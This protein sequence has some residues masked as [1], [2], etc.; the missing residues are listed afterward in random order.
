MRSKS[1][2]TRKTLPLTVSA[3]MSTLSVIL[4][5]LYNVPLLNIIAVFTCALP[6]TYAGAIYGTRWAILSCITSSVVIGMVQSPL[7]AYWFLMLF[8]IM[9]AV[10]GILLHRREKPGKLLFKGT[11]ITV[12]FFILG[13]Y[14]VESAMGLNEV[15][16]I[17]S[18]MYHAKSWAVNLLGSPKPKPDPA[19]ALSAISENINTLIS[20]PQFLL[21]ASTRI[22][23]FIS[24]HFLPVQGIADFLSEEFKYR[25]FEKITSSYFALQTLTMKVAL[26]VQP[27]NPFTLESAYALRALMPAMDWEFKRIIVHMFSEQELEYEANM[28][29]AFRLLRDWIKFP[30][31][32]SLTSTLPPLF[33][34]YF[35]AALIFPRFGTYIRPLPPLFLWKTPELIV[36]A[37]LFSQF[38]QAWAQFN[39]YF[40]MANLFQQLFIG[41]SMMTFLTGVGV[42]MFFTLRHKV[43]GVFRLF[44]MMASIFIFPFIS[45]L[46]MID[47]FMDMRSTAKL[48]S[49][50]DGPALMNA[51]EV[52]ALKTRVTGHQ[53]TG[54][55]NT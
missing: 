45:I 51:E 47:A 13:F 24:S 42:I 29:M 23:S 55:R 14:V 49:L 40:F 54:A 16:E 18:T 41:G 15:D 12:I 30:L 50:P 46:G 43:P 9:G 11:L 27:N 4:F 39:G 35:A 44:I 1:R 53:R 3:M 20:A 17:F 48:P 31:I 38:A 21:P 34:N 26:I 5:L 36:L 52:K 32:L 6:V 7:Q 22:T 28:S 2:T 33:V 10:T 19:K 25:S 8:G 37:T